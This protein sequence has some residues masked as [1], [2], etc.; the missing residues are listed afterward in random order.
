MANVRLSKNEGHF[1]VNLHINYR[2]FSYV[3][4]AIRREY[5]IDFEAL[6]ITGLEKR[7]YGV[8]VHTPTAA[9]TAES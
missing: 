7:R 4:P 3:A 2:Q 5:S 8:Q 6:G 1:G 9:Q